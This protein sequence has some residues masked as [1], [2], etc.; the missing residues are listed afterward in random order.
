MA[1]QST[2]VVKFSD[3]KLAWLQTFIC[4]SK[5]QSYTRAG[6][7][8]G[9]DQSEVSRRV[10][11]LGKWFGGPL[12]TKTRPPRLTPHGQLARQIAEDTL[13]ALCN[14]N[15]ALNRSIA[16]AALSPQDEECLNALKVVWLDQGGQA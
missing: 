8:L 1:K 11:A 13:W 16:K 15:N 4:V 7:H 5:L 12:L 2:D 10:A 6:E 9:I 3:V 14:F